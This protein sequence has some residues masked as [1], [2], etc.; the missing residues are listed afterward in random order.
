MGLSLAASAKEWL[1]LLQFITCYASVQEKEILAVGK[2][3]LL[4]VMG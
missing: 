4:V 3:M 1:N 2:G